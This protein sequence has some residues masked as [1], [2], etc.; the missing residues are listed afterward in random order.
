MPKAVYL[1]VL[2]GLS[3]ES[4]AKVAGKEDEVAF[5]CRP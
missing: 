4:L 2:T 1:S 3:K 5:Y